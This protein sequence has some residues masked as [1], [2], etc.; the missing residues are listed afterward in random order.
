MPPRRWASASTSTSSPRA[1]ATPSRDRAPT[2]TSRTATEVQRLADFY[3]N[4]ELFNNT[5]KSTQP[6]GKVTM[7][8]GAH[9][10]A[11]FVQQ[12]RLTAT[13]DRE[14]HFS[15]SNVYS[16]GG[17]LYG[18]K[19]TSTWGNRITTTFLASYNNQGGSDQ[20]TFEGFSGSGPT[21]TIHRAASLTGG[22]LIG[23]GRLVSG[24]NFEDGT[25]GAGQASYSY[26]P[27]SQITLRA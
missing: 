16:T 18:G 22:K 27:S 11:A 12:D 2:R 1:A 5:T 24:G 8:A 25:A 14:Y 17:G 26:L 15:R 10:I 4:A 9:Q 23:D 21:L 19:V 6:Y 13:G 20:R 7:Q 3:P